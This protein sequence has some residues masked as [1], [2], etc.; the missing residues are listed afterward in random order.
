MMQFG[1]YQMSEK[2]Q[3]QNADMIAMSLVTLFYSKF[4]QYACFLR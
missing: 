4:V 2:M 1:L 3:T